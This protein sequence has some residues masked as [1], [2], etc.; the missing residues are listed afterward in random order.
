VSEVLKKM[1]RLAV[2]VVVMSV[3]FVVIPGTALANHGS[4]ALEVTPE[5]ST[6]TIP[7]NVTLT[8]HLSQAPATGA[9]NDIEIDFEYS[10]PGDSYTP[11]TPDGTCTISNPA[12][13]CSPPV[14]DKNTAG[15]FLARAWIDHDKTNGDVGGTTEADGAEGRY[16]GL[17]P[18]DPTT[19]P[20]Y[21]FGDCT[22]DDDDPACP[23][24]PPG[25]PGNSEPDNT[26]V[27]SVVFNTGPAALDCD[28][29][30]EL[31]DEGEAES[32]ICRVRDQFGNPVGD[33]NIDGE[34]ND[35]ANDP[36][37]K[38]FVDTSNDTAD[39]DDFCTTDADGNCQNATSIDGSET[40][41]ALLC[42]WVD[43][44]GAGDDLFDNMEGPHDVDGA[45]CDN[46]ESIG[47]PENDD[48]TDI[49]RKRWLAGEVPGDPYFGF[50]IARDIELLP[51]SNGTAGYEL[52]GYG[53]IHAF[54]G[55]PPIAAGPYW[56]GWD[57]ARSFELD[58]F[59][60]DYSGA[61]GYVL[62]GWGGTHPWAAGDHTVPPGQ[63]GPYFPGYDIA[64]DLETDANYPVG[65]VLDGWGGIHPTGAA[66]PITD[67][68]YFP[69]QDV[70]RD[71][72]VFGSNDGYILTGN[73]GVHDFGSA[74]SITD[75][76]FFG[77]DIARD[78]YSVA[79]GKGYVFDGY[80]GIHPFGGLSNVTG[81]PYWPG[82]DIARD[83]E[84]FDA[85]AYT[86]DG[87]G[88]R[89][90]MEYA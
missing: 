50:D 51:G 63:S 52:D 81:A 32:Y 49:V 2:S 44:A 86:L 68:P 19:S 71:I 80:G 26:D 84:A 13:S 73:G 35:G 17:Y 57:I 4:R 33:T 9:A 77:F 82:W 28:P 24:A 62:D 37:N 3:G 89:H 25:T 48:T 76:P 72:E 11:S 67:G 83:F 64:R 66:G 45:E 87:F 40:G 6:A 46:E 61:S 70:A 79:D 59:N 85:G 5:V 43:D 1:A 41:A 23:E 69:G 58:P 56:P 15:E 65:H 88:G 34:N 22:P 47:D 30:S 27:V 54:G 29:E 7:D 38:N 8:A 75:S 60:S 16:S 20:T 55:A 90:E 31:N 10:G 53:G 36:D 21:P 14:L 42:F 12:T 74:T 18:Y 78:L 39:Y